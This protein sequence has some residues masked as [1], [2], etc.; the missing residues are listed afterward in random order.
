MGNRDHK[1]RTEGNE[2][3]PIISPLTGLW[4]SASMEEQSNPR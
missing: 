1:H 3:S 2:R 4:I